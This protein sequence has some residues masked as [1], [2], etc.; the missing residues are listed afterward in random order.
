METMNIG[1]DD[2]RNCE[3][4]EKKA[5]NEMETDMDVD[6]QDQDEAKGT[7]EDNPPPST[8]DKQDGERL[9]S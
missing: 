8:H 1:D 6:G 2:D 9:L 7:I 3:E 5:L 4:T